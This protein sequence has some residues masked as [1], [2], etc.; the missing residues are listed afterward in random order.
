MITYNKE[1]I[2]RHVWRKSNLILS[3]TRPTKDDKSLGK[4]VKGKKALGL[5]KSF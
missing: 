4:C 3:K 2:K 1:S 5:D